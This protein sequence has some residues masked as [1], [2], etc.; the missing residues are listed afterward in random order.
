M[1]THFYSKEKPDKYIEFIFNSVNSYKGPDKFYTIFKSLC[2]EFNFSPD[3]L[4]YINLLYYL[5]N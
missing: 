4:K 3:I 1:M 2:I 5:C